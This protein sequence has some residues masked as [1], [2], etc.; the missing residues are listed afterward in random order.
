M[1]MNLFALYHLLTP[2]PGR[3]R[4]V[5]SKC[6]DLCKLDKKAR[7]GIICVH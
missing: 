4:Q 6:E 7:C 1:A 3:T 5:G 2:R